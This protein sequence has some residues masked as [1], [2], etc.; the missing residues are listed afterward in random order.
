MRRLYD[1]TYITHTHTQ[2]ITYVI[3]RQCTYT[4][5]TYRRQTK[6]LFT[7]LSNMYKSQSQLNIHTSAI[8]TTQPS[9]ECVTRIEFCQRQAKASFLGSGAPASRWVFP[10]RPDLKGDTHIPL[11]RTRTARNGGSYKSQTRRM[12]E[13]EEEVARARIST[14]CGGCHLKRR[15]RRSEWVGHL[16]LAEEI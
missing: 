13:G 2:R 9:S 15:R 12:F 1:D 7:S 6:C 16:R 10:P 8:T 14:V 4:H 3:P 5:Y 11:I